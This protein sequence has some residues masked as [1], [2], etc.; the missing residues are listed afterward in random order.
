[1]HALE[2]TIVLLLFFISGKSSRRTMSRV[3]RL[4]TRLK[5][6][7]PNADSVT[8]SGLLSS[9]KTPKTRRPTYIG[10]LGLLA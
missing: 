7:A 2:I 5:L 1:M 10:L 9:D 8:V 4:N 3:L 6:T